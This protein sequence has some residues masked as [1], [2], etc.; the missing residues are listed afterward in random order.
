MARRGRFGGAWLGASGCDE[1][2]H[3]KAWQARSGLACHGRARSGMAGMDWLGEARHGESRQ[4]NTIRIWSGMMVPILIAF[5]LVAALLVAD[6]NS[7]RSDWGVV[8]WLIILLVI[9][10]VMWGL[11]APV[12]GFH[13]SIY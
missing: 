9:G 5:G 6:F 11:I 3:G 10:L 7:K 8:V 2:G 1:V 13:D 12:I 4:A